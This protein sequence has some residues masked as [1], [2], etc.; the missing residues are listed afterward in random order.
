LRQRWIQ[1]L[2]CLPFD[3]QHAKPKAL[4]VLNDRIVEVRAETFGDLWNWQCGQLSTQLAYFSVQSVSLVAAADERFASLSV[5]RPSARPNTQPRK[6]ICFCEQPMSVGVL[7]ER[8]ETQ[9]DREYNTD[10]ADQVKTAARHDSLPRFAGAP[11]IFYN[12]ERPLS[13]HKV[14]IKIMAEL[15]GASR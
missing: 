14:V 12:S 10:V 3:N 15:T 9:E 11:S 6:P 13:S 1:V 2:V 8:M 4:V 7:R 5:E